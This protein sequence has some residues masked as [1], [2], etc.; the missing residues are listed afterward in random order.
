MADNGNWEISKEATRLHHEAFVCDFTLPYTDLGDHRKKM[1]TLPRFKAA[2][3]NCVSLSLGGDTGGI[4]DTMKLIARERAYFLRRPESYVLVQTSQ[5]MSRAQAED[6]MGVIFHFQGTDPLQGSLE[7]VETY[8]TLG[9]RHMLLAYNVRN[10]VGDGCFEPEDSGLSMFGKR[11]IGE[12]NRVGMLVDGSH[13]GRRSSLEAMECSESPCI[14]SHANPSGLH[15]HPRNITDEQIR[16]CAETGGVVGILGISNM[17]GSDGD[18][19]ARR[20]VEH[21]DYCVQLVGPDHV[22]LSLDFVFD[23]EATYLWALA[24]AGG[25]LPT[26]Y[27]VDM[28]LTPPE[29]YPQITE[30]LLG[31][32][33]Q[34]TD[35]GKVL[36]GNW[37]RVSSQVW[38]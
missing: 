2:G 18:V 1:E 19:S 16:A 11:L 10:P 22:G 8:Y 32:G 36:G 3:V 17:L 38:K 7:M 29:C 9:V 31:I 37:R 4:A 28:P 33:Y 24:Q 13:T 26:G 15:Q 20:I 27:S 6:R 12:M 5:D 23:P 35:I 30:R 34:P 14:F 21:I 25:N